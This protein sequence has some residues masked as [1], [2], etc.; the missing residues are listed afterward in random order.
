M[1][2]LNQ[3][4]GESQLRLHDACFDKCVSNFSTRTFDAQ[5]KACIG[6]CFKS[7]VYTFKYSNEVLNKHFES[8]GLHN[9]K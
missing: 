5:E 9:V 1:D 7:F 2:N 6:N 4:G 3:W 8:A